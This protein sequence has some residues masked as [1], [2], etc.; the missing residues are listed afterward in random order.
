MYNNVSSRLLSS[1]TMCMV[2]GML[3]TSIVCAV[4][5]AF[6]Q[7]SA[8]EDPAGASGA[9]GNELTP[10]K[11]EF[12]G[13]DVG[14]GQTAQIVTLFRNTGGAPLTIGK[15][16]LVPS[17]NVSA[18][19]GNNQ[20]SLEPLRPG[21]ECAITVS[22]TGQASGKFRIGMLIN[23]NG[24]S[25]LTNAAII[26]NV[27]NDSSGRGMS[28]DIEAFP[29]DIDFGQVTTTAPLVR[30]LG[31]RNNTGSIITIENISLAASPTSGFQMSAPKCKELRP[32]QACVATVTWTPT[33]E[34]IV[35]GVVVLRHDGPSGAMRIGLKGGYQP[36]KMETAARFANAVPGE[37]LLVAD[38]DKIDFGSEVDGAASITVSLVNQGDK[39][40]TI[41]KLRLAGSDNGLSLS[42]SD[43]KTGKVLASGEACALTVNWQP[44]RIGPVI[45]DIQVLHT[46]A[47]GVLVLPVRGTAEQPVSNSSGPQVSYSAQIPDMPKLSGGKL[48]E[49]VLQTAIEADKTTAAG[50]PVISS[51]T[52]ANALTAGNTT[53]PSLDGY[54]ISS[55]GNDHAIIAGPKGRLIIKDQEAQV[56][57]GVRWV[58]RIVPEGVELASGKNVVLL[59]FDPSL[60]VMQSVAPTSGVLGTY[61]NMGV[62]S[63]V[64]SLSGA[65]VTGNTGLNGMTGGV[66]GSG[67]M[68][69]N[70]M[71]MTGGGMQSGSSGYRR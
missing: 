24:K 27:G 38:L 2:M 15:I 28:S 26:G 40:L 54:R 52:R 42:N 61:G 53:T 60:T 21:V 23:H 3:L 46:G 16:D 36:K 6:A 66:G 59:I 63:N 30:S 1:R 55:V 56:I 11:D 32:S 25:R 10:R 71:G 7:I 68:G 44:R 69:M 8:F 50:S 62:I 58:P 51:Q 67:G 47:R 41:N 37:G 12:D 13:G 39:E 20:C 29:A 4:P 19:L 43:C 31:L 64:N 17:S 48:D 70:S 49:K 35:E 65:A 14:Q 5:Q 33:V 18:V 57:A 45:D 9:G 34:G 22:V